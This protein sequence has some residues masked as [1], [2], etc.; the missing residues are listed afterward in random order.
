VD[1]IGL[2]IACSLANDELQGRRQGVLQKIAGAIIDF[3]ELDNGYLYRFPADGVWIAELAS[4]V[5]FERQC[6]PF[7]R[8]RLTAEPALGDISLEVT[9][10]PGTKEFL[11][12]IFN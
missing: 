2:P 11:T 12:K 4:F 9:G 6:C 8:F 10:P 7:L 1:D 5:D 3:Q